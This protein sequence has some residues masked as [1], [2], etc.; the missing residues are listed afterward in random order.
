MLVIGV[1]QTLDSRIRIMPIDPSSSETIIKK[2]DVQSFCTGL[3]NFFS[4][5]SDLIR[6]YSDQKSSLSKKLSIGDDQSLNPS[7]LG[8]LNLHKGHFNRKLENLK[9]KSLIQGSNVSSAPSN[10]RPQD[11]IW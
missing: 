8:K 11:K 5:K 2:K 10:K 9:K 1:G 3:E 7:F 6:S 4:T